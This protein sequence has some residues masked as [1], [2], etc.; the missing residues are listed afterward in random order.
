MAAEL[1]ATGILFSDNTRLDSKYDIIPQTNGKM[2]FFE[3][4]APTG[5]T[6]E[7]ANNDKALRVVTGNGGGT[8]GSTAFSSAFP[9]SLKTISGTFPISGSVGGHT[10]TTDELPSHTHA[11]GGSV[12]LSP[13][14]GDV[15]NGGG[16]TRTSPASGAN[17]GPTGGSHNHPFSSGSA[18]FTKDV[19]LRVQYMDVI[20][21]R[22]N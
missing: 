7:T 6:K 20:I 15:R 21:C 9:T 22:F 12:G 5:W 17:P 19:D 10:L 1:D 18:S 4:A 3:S 13:G 16:W 11:N 8:G 2:V 14:N